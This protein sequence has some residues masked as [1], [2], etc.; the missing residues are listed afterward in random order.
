MAAMVCPMADA[1]VKQFCGVSLE[2]NTYTGFLPHQ[3]YFYTQNGDFVDVVNNRVALYGFSDT[4]D[5]F[6][7]ETPLRS[8]TAIYADLSA[9]AGDGPADF[10]PS[11]QL[12]EGT[13]FYPDWDAPGI[14]MSGIIKRWINVWPARGRSIKITFVAG[15]TADEF[16]GTTPVN[17]RPSPV[18]IK[19][20]AI[21][22]A[23]QHISTALAFTSGNGI[24]GQGGIVQE[25]LGDAAFTYSD[26]AARL[27]SMQLEV[28]PMAQR[29]LQPW[30]RMM[31]R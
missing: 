6:V 10:G 31:R 23:V 7:P 13:D 19:S 25:R 21:L 17:F 29:M 18:G 5:V 3:D 14:C 20:A 28:P 26:A 15:Y 22:T 2:Q 1:A 30:V 4:R 27:L 8:V 24:G 16:A 12:V 11:T 9:L